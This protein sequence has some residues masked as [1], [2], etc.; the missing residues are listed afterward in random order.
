MWIFNDLIIE[1]VVDGVIVIDCQ[2][3]VIIMNL[4][5]EVIIGY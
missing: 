5:V 4:V 1:N 3:D 2:G